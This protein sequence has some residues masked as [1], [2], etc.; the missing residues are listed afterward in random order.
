M[1]STSAAG[2]RSGRALTAAE[3]AARLGVKR[4]SLYAYVSR[5]ILP[6]RVAPDGKTSR[7]DLDDVERLVRSRRRGRPPD[8]SIEL[9]ITTSITRISDQGVWYRGRPLAE[10]AGSWS[11]ERTAEWL[12]TGVD[13]GEPARAWAAAPVGA[14]VAAP[15]MWPRR[16][17]ALVALTAAAASLDPHRDP[18]GATAAGRRLIATFADHV[19][20][21]G[22][23]RAR[24]PPTRSIAAR[25]AARLGP[26][27]ATAR[28]APLLD[29]TLVLLADHDL[30]SSTLAARIAGSTRADPYGV[31]LAGLGVVSGPL[32]GG[33]SR[34]AVAFLDELD[35]SSDVPAAIASWL[36]AGRRLPGFGHKIYR[37]TDPRYTLLADAL[38]AEDRWPSIV[39]EV[40][41]AARDQRGLRP[42]IDLAIAALIRGTGLPADTGELLFA[43][44]RTAGWIAHAIEEYG[45]APVR[46]R[47]S[48]VYVGPMDPPADDPQVVAKSSRF[49]ERVQPQ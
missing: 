38:V 20:P 19:P 44:A 12:W 2:T 3:A 25:L 24:R 31:V 11:F 33:A 35:R 15:A 13:V 22:S 4:A 37:G 49:G 30:A 48:S 23:G 21:P 40:V 46:F 10:L 32:H 26:S 47:P 5:G 16:L 1:E 14:I 7:F 8:P 18:M 43:V 6:R 29:R 28:F 34:Q 9:T 36:A 39:T 41:D 17:D 42:N 45:E 27:I